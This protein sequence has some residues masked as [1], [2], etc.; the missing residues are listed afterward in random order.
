VILTMHEDAAYLRQGLEIGVAGYV[1]KRSAA[2]ELSRAIHTV[3]AGGIYL[4]P[5]V[6]AR[7][8]CRSANH[9]NGGPNTGPATDLSPR[10]IEVLRLTAL[11]HSNKSI[12]GTLLIGVKS[13]DTYK[14]RAMEKLGFRNRVE[15]IRFALSRRWLGEP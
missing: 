4:D 12:A 1:L 14:A 8:V 11:G 7:A 3:A 6:A 13:V 10:E 9:Q 2:D 15:V 5:A